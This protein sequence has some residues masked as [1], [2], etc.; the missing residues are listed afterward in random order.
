VADEIHMSGTPTDASLCR[1]GR[2]L[3]LSSASGSE[4]PLPQALSERV[5]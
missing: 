5:P 3:S 2:A 1:G 4:C